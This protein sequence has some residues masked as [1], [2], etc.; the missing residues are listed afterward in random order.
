MINLDRSEV[1][2]P[3]QLYSLRGKARARLTFCYA[4]PF[5]KHFRH[6]NEIRIVNLASFK[7]L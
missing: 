6:Y 7:L 4:L 5:G 2:R 3:E 1:S